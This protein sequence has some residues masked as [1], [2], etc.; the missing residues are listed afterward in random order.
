MFLLNV[1]GLLISTVSVGVLSE[2]DFNRGMDELLF[3]SFRDRPSVLST[4]K[5]CFLGIPENHENVCEY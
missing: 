3:K 1:L 4:V 2:T 5:E